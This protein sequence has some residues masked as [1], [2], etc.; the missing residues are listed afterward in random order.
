M[1][2]AV[3]DFGAGLSK[4]ASQTITAKLDIDGQDT[5]PGAGDD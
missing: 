3:E 1:S 4:Q 5:N 2:A